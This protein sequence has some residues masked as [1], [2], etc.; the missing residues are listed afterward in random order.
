MDSETPASA[1]VSFFVHAKQRINRN[2]R[3][4]PERILQNL[5][6]QSSRDVTHVT[7]DVTLAIC[8]T[9][10]ASGRTTAATI[11]AL[12]NLGG[13]LV[14]WTPELNDAPAKARFVFATEAARDEFVAAATVIAGISLVV[15]EVPVVPV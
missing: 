14:S 6:I 3:A 9:N 8:R 7:I 5:L 15:P 4:T 11:A 13:R 2:I 12:A 10:P 1:G